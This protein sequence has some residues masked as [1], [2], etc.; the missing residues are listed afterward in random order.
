MPM[1]SKFKTIRAILWGF[2]PRLCGKALPFRPNLLP[3]PLIC[4]AAVA[5]VSS[6]AF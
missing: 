3:F 4:A 5:R 2:A 6:P 1:L